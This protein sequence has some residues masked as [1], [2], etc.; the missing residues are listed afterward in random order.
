MEYIVINILYLTYNLVLKCHSNIIWRLMDHSKNVHKC[1]HLSF[2]TGKISK[3]TKLKVDI[4]GHLWTFVDKKK[5][6]QI[7]YLII[8]HTLNSEFFY[9]FAYLTYIWHHNTMFSFISRRSEFHEVPWINSS[10]CSSEIRR[11]I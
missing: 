1:P 3:W 7:T 11:G 10:C 8:Y 4:C 5:L 9:E 2:Y 6:C